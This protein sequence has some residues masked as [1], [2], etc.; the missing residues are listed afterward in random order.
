[1][2][3][4]KLMSEGA[5]WPSLA[6]FAG[7]RSPLMGLRIRLICHRCHCF[8]ESILYSDAK[9]F[10][11]HCGKGGNPPVHGVLGKIDFSTPSNPLIK[12]LVDV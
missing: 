8:E 12:V 3:M 2:D 1:M 5:I 10:S 7:M 4:K 6:I 9:R 11:K